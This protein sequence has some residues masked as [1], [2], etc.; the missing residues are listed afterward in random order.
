M[1]ATSTSNTISI[2]LAS[3]MA[4]A[5]VSLL[6]G[7]FIIYGVGMAHSDM[8]HDTAHDT[9]HSYGFPCH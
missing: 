7:V 6:L 1:A 2:P 8:L 3:R 9:R 5:V 4:T